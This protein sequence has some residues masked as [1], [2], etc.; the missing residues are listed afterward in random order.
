MLISFSKS[1]SLLSVS[2]LAAGCAAVGGQAQLFPSAEEAVAASFVNIPE[3]MKNNIKQDETMRL[4][5]AAR[6]KASRD[7]Q[8]KVE[9]LNAAMPITYPANG[10]LMG[11]WKKGEALAQS[12][13]GMR[14]GDVTSRATGGNCYACHQLKPQELSYGT[15]GPTLLK[16]GALRGNT[17]AVVKYTYDKIY[18]TQ[19]FVGCSNMPRFGQ[20]KI[21][22]P[23][24]IADIVALLLDPESPVNK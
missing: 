11:D 10:K 22:S 17:E 13:Y 23:E 19:Q 6:D 2:M 12:G 18:N 16:Y 8:A 21:L 24:Q 1:M 20:N 4:C 7:L 15:L 9:K 14:K 3:H 5:S